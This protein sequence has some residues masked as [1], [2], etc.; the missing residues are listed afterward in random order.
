MRLQ[1]FALKA[2]RLGFFLYPFY[3]KKN[4]SALAWMLGNDFDKATLSP[5]KL[6]ATALVPT[7]DPLKLGPFKRLEAL[8]ADDG[9]KYYKGA[10][11]P[12]KWHS[13]D[14][15]LE[16]HPR[17]RTKGDSKRFFNLFEN[18]VVT[19]LH[20]VQQPGSCYMH[21]AITH[22]AHVYFLHNCHK[23]GIARSTRRCC[24]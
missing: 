6:L 15:F 18:G 11:T 23:Q 7:K 5:R 19:P 3:S 14:K 12:A 13:Y 2:I 8:M 24:C 1:Q 16:D 9:D 10:E 17:W 22:H 21:A 20:H 4:K